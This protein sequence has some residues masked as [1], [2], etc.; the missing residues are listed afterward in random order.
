[1]VVWMMLCP[2]AE[3]EDMHHTSLAER[4]IK[5]KHDLYDMYHS[6]KDEVASTQS[7]TKTPHSY[8]N[9]CALL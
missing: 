2:Q 6:C 9:K 8:S 3:L 4:D 7:H 5:H 1:M